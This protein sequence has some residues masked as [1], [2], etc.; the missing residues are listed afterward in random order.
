MEKQ[1]T[2]KLNIFSVVGFACAV[3]FLIGF[4]RKNGV[5][6]SR[7]QAAKSVV[8]V[9]DVIVSSQQQHELSMLPVERVVRPKSGKN[10][11]TKHKMSERSLDQWVNEFGEIAIS[12]AI[13]RGIPAGISLAF[14]MMKVQAGIDINTWND[15]M[16]KVV[17]PLVHLKR[18][19]PRADISNY[20]KYSANSDLW[21]QGLG[22]TGR[23]DAYDLK[24]IMEHYNLDNF[25]RTVRA[26]IVAG[27]QQPKLAEK[28]V[29]I[30]NQV[31]ATS[32]MEYYETD[33][34]LERANRVSEWKETYEEV[35]GHE[36]AEE[37]ARKKLKTGKYLSDEDLQRLVDE[38]NAETEQAL[39]NK[40]MFMGRRINRSHPTA[41]QKTD[42]TNPRNAQARGELYHQKINRTK[43]MK[44]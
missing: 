43:K 19:A 26:N 24:Q 8:Q 41:S 31:V 20:F 18:N 39:E 33:K 22:R 34:E 11:T 5:E 6:I 27:K 37:V 12:Q 29:E 35:V 42:I 38:T 3:I 32:S 25:D 21:A 2:P 10:A 1:S 16:E 13:D 44:D 28:A 9:E 36:V 7:S 15:Y 17:Q 14:G 40:V 4:L 30:A 23:F